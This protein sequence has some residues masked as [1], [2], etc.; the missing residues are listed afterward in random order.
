MG[1]YSAAERRTLAEILAA[2][3]APSCP[4]CGTGLAVREVEPPRQV[5][6]VRRRVWL[7]CPGCK[8]T[9]ALDVR[10]GGPPSSHPDR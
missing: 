10:G 7:L 6:Y 9:A 2:G 1:S 5:S 8:R 4:V 3:D